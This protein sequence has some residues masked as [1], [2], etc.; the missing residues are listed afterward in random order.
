[1]RFAMMFPSRVRIRFVDK[2][3]DS[4]TG[5]QE[6]RAEGQVPADFWLSTL[7]YLSLV[8]ALW[9]RAD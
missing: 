6:T 2:T 5:S 7:D 8:A 1:M 3:G 9:A 4:R